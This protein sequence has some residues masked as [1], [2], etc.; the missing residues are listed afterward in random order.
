M[1]GDVLEQFVDHLRVERGASPHTVRAYARTLGGL[2]DRLA[3]GGR[4][5]ETARKIDVRGFLFRVGRGRSSA[6]LARH[7]AA[8]RTL[9]RW[10][11]DRGV[12]DVGIADDLQPPKVGRHLPRFL[13]E[14]K[15]EDVVEGPGLP[16]RDRAIVE[17]LYGSGIRVGELCALDLGDVDLHTGMVRVR[18]GKGDKERR[19][20]M[21]EA[22]AH[23][24]GRYLADAAIEPGPL[25]LNARGA[26]MS[27][28]TAHRV[29]QQAGTLADA[30]GL[31][32]HA[33]RHSF[34]THLLDAGAD[35]R[36][37]QELLGHASLSTTQR[38]TH[39]SVQALLDTYRA[40]HPRARRGSDG[41]DDPG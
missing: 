36:A 30:P 35:L 13:S 23:A 19:V 25:F 27:T 24:L 41:P 21:G 6:T 14:A 32:P 39:V 11:I 28:R 29:V 2:R 1:G 4:T 8:I 7:V 26:R 16:A 9:Y 17:L 38:Y 33:L 3:A 37:I 12:V 20:P 22:A 31:H 5:F 18:H 40:A 10:L 34:A 15:A